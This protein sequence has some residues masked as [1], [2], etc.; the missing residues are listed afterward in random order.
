VKMPGGEASNLAT[1]KEIDNDDE[2]EG[3]YD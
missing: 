2:D 3:E 1:P